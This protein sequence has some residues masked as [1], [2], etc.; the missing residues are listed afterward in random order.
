MWRTTIGYSDSQLSVQEHWDEVISRLGLKDPQ[1]GSF[2]AIEFT[3]FING[4]EPK[5]GFVRKME[6]S[7]GTASY[8]KIVQYNDKVPRLIVHLLKELENDESAFMIIRCDLAP[9]E[10]G[11]RW[12]CAISKKY[13]FNFFDMFNAFFDR[14]IDY[15]FHSKLFKKISKSEY[16]KLYPFE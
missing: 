5:P 4:E 7:L 9:L 11:S 6:G 14:P 15:I 12:Y 2:R 3:D 1:K 13:N 16:H 10:N 8:L